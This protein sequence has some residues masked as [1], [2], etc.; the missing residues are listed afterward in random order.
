MSKNHLQLKSYFLKSVK[1]LHSIF[2]SLNVPTCISFSGSFVSEIS[3]LSAWC[4]NVTQILF[5]SLNMWV[6]LVHKA[7]E[8]ILFSRVEQSSGSHG[9]CD[10]KWAMKNHM[11][12]RECWD[13]CLL[14]QQEQAYCGTSL[15]TNYF[16]IT[17]VMICFPNLE[18]IGWICK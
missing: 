15:N 7:F 5:K 10:L 14:T 1:Y 8:G 12:P 11:G 6:F 18:K 2:D 9:Y 17:F 16:I 13:C 4:I 3:V